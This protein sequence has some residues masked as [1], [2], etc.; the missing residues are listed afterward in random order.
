[1][2]SESSQDTHEKLTHKNQNIFL[3]TNSE[4]MEKK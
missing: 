1:M 2:N 4:H 3:Y